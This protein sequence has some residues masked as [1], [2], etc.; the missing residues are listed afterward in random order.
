M[1]SRR[2]SVRIDPGVE[3]RLRRRAS[4]ARKSESAIVRDAL[5]AYLKFGPLAPSAYDVALQAGV[6][7]CVKGAPP[8]LSTNADHM[9]GFGK[10]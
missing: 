10:E 6:I 3:A 9:K 5:D 7:G 4:L 2:I 8:D 1:A